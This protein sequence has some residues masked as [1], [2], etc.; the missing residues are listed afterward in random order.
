[1]CSLFIDQDYRVGG[2]AKPLSGK[3]QALLGGGLHA[4]PVHR[5]LQRGG[6]ILTHLQDMGRQLWPLGQH[7]AVHVACRKAVSERMVRT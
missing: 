2:D 4:D 7:R 1:M 6:N 3:A 5:D